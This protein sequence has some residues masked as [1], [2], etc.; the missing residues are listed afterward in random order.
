MFSVGER[1]VIE[2]FNE[3]EFSSF[4]L[5]D[6]FNKQTMKGYPKKKENLQPEETGYYVYG[7]NIRRQYEYKIL[8]DEVYL[9]KV[10]SSHPI[11][12]YTSSVGEIGIITESFYRSGDNGAFQGLLPKWNNERRDLQFVLVILKKQFE[13]FGY[14]TSMSNIINLEF[15]LPV[16]SSGEPDWSLMKI[17][18]SAIEK[19][20]IRDVVRY[21]DKKINAT[22]EVINKS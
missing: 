11:L 10:D 15:S 2:R 18:I 14:A 17:F 1:E 4:K 21:A 5:K 22:K 12:A 13:S 9:H 6:L 20:V 19:V 16:Q 7:Q 3:L 8:M